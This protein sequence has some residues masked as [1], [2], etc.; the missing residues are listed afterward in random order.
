MTL[1]EAVCALNAT[2]GEGPVWIE[3]RLW[4]VD[5]L[6]RRIHCF[7]PEMAL[8][9]SWTAPSP[10]GWVLP[11]EGGRMVAGLRDGVHLFDPRTGAF[12]PYALLHNEPDSNRLNDACVDQRGRLWFGTMDLN[13]VQ[14]TG[15]LYRHDAGI[16]A[17][18]GLRPV[19]ITNGPALSPD[20]AMLYAV[21]TRGGVVTAHDVADDGS[22]GPA[23]LFTQ[24]DPADGFPDG[25]T[26]D[27]EGCVWIA[28][29]G[30][31][32]VRRY[33][34]AGKLMETVSLPCSNVTKV[35][36]GGEGLRTAYV[37][38]ARTGLSRTQLVEQPRAGDIFAF[39]AGVAGLLCTPIKL[40]R[41]K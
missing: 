11:A 34:A 19:P 40:R 31:W 21:D 3:D 35:A 20:A 23:R 2:L 32:G 22:L 18:T 25:A 8:L 4:L 10:V 27:A 1:P 33:D 28:L 26:I 17:N 29:F 15:R 9:L 41:A 6:E 12:T 38:T 16:I 39:D 37:T 7:R 24:I 5:I 13:G 36:F 14:A 30:G